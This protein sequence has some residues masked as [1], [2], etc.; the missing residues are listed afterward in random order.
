MGAGFG[1]PPGRPCSASTL[2]STLLVGGACRQP[3]LPG[4]H[5]TFGKWGSE[6]LSVSV[7]LSIK[8]GTLFQ[9]WCEV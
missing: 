1:A 5:V 6:H 2:E 7:S 4:V 3:H 8:R 9:G